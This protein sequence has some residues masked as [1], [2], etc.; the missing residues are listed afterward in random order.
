MKT[1]S[2]KWKKTFDAVK[3]MRE[4][5]DKISLEIAD[6]NFKELKAYFK[7]SGTLE[8]QKTK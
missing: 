2:K 6:M 1:K 3:S 7:Q 5:R 4:I 8:S